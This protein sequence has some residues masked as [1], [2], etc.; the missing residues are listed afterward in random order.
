VRIRGIGILILASLIGSVALTREASY[1]K[2]GQPRN[3]PANQMPKELEGIQIDQKPGTKLD[4][5]LKFRNE[6]GAE[7][8]LGDYFNKG[9]PVMLSLVY[10]SCPSLCNLHLNGVADVFKNM[11]M[12]PGKEFEALAVSFDP[13]ETSDV[14]AKKKANYITELGKP[15]AAQGWHF[16]TGDAASGKAL[17]ESVGF[18]YRWDEAGQQW[19][20]SSAAIF[21]NPDGTVSKYIH[22]VVF[23]P[24]SV[25]LALV[26]SSHG[27]VGSI[28]DSIMLFC[29]KFDPNQNKYVFYAFNIMRFGAGLVALILGGFLFNFWLSTRRRWR[30]GY[31]GT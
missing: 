20:H 17:A 30:E 12:T 29:F 9:K 15:E 10:F 19:A 5:N 2:P 1:Y 6:S 4:L 13:S 27:K 3:E 7:V 21:V 31:R 25:R 23:D 8:T 14:A 16:L 28:V 22:G 18:N 24:Q 26:D 11:T